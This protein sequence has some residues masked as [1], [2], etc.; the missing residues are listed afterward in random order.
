MSNSKLAFLERLFGKGSYSSSTKEFG[1]FCPYCFHY[2]KKLFINI[3]ID[4]WH[5][6][7]CG[8]AGKNLV[9]LIRKVGKNSDVDEYARLHKAKNVF[10]KNVEKNKQLEEFSIKLPDDFVPLVNC[11]NSI[12][13]QR[14]I[15]YLNRRGITENDILRHKLG[16][17]FER[18][19]EDRVILP[20][21]NAEGKLVYFTARSIN[22]S[23]FKYQDPDTP[24]GYKKSIVLNELN[25]DWNKPVVL[26]EG[27]FDALKCE[28]AIPLFGSSLT[29]EY[30][31]F[32]SIV[33]NCTKIYLGLDADAQ[34][35]S[36]KIAELLMNYDKEVY[37]I[38]VNPF[39]DIGDMDREDF[40]SRYQSAK[41]VD[42]SSIYKQKLRNICR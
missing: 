32:Q 3:E 33:R 31:I 35:K 29:K 37:H 38:D 21:F 7:V 4:S 36:M 27:V 13:G 11:K 28:N 39:K 16:I 18:K 30:G 9:Y 19:Y 40:N 6:F 1:I 25:I 2:K 8:K 17:S 41:M 42:Y 15:S 14:A 26:V 23:N 20:M 12:M 10:I 34:D 22:G 5:C 24:K